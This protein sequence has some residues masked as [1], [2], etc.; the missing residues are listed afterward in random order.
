MLLLQTRAEENRLASGRGQGKVVEIEG[1]EEG[2]PVGGVAD[3]VA[4]VDEGGFVPEDA[5]HL[6]SSDAPRAP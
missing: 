3:G 2:D 5:K 1:G 4:Q 6:Q